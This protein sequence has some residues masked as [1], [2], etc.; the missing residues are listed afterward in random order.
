MNAHDLCLIID[1]DQGYLRDWLTLTRS[2]KGNLTAQT[3]ELH[4]RFRMKATD[5]SARSLRK[6]VLNLITER[7]KWDEVA[8]HYNTKVKEG[9]SA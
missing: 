4:F 7:I 9:A 8:D 2:W 3:A 5:M 6:E 1:N